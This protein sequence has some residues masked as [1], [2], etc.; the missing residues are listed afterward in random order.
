MPAPQPHRPRRVVQ[1]Q[2]AGVPL[3]VLILAAIG[4]ALVVF[5]AVAGSTSLG[6]FLVGALIAAGGALLVIGAYMWL[7]RWEPE[8]PSFL[9][10]AFLWGAGVAT[11]GSLLLQEI[12]YFA[13]WGD[14]DFA[15]AVIGAPIFEEGLKGAFLLVMMTGLRRKEMTSLTDVLV[16]AGMSGI[17]FAFVENLLYFGSA[18]STADIGF[19]FFARILMGAFAH[20]FFTT[21]T[22]LGVWA[23]MHRRTGGGAA[24]NIIGGYALA[25]LLHAL[26]NGSAGFGLGAYF[27]VY[28][29]VMMPSFIVLV[30][31]ALRSRKREGQI[32]VNELP[33]MVWSGL[34][35]PQE[36]G[37]L[38]DLKTRKHRTENAPAHMSKVL[39]E[40]ID[41]VTELA[42]VR[43]RIKRG[44][45]TPDVQAHQA[46][47]AAFLAS[48][49]QAAHDAMEP[50]LSHAPHIQPAAP[51]VQAPFPMD[52]HP[53]GLPRD[54]MSQGPTSQGPMPHH[55]QHGASPPPQGM[56]PQAPG[57]APQQNQWQDYRRP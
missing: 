43:D 24:V 45:S 15:S 4:M 38:G 10:W 46:E 1:V 16:Y 55:A 9:V 17:G 47:L 13:L 40:F 32:V 36:A 57:M 44:H 7:D 21:M 34:V 31:Q 27:T 6:V 33:E 2:R 54:P 3:L 41:A 52:Y 25:V 19:M 12:A 20:P 56:P 35:T 14:S 28:V 48:R 26:W 29:L 51:P 50:Y 5:L 18:E 22:A 23:A 49:H 39:R 8:P 37:W 42:F 53:G 11:V 30:N